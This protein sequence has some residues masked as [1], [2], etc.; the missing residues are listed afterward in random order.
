MEVWS[1]GCDGDQD[2]LLS[3]HL[4]ASNISPVDRVGWLGYIES[5]DHAYLKG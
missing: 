5:D 3:S 1:D 2:M 4:P